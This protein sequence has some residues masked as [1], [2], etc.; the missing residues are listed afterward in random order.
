MEGSAKASRRGSVNKIMIVDDDKEIAQLVSLYLQNEGF[1]TI[2]RHHGQDALDTLEQ[3]NVSLIVL[4]VMM[5]HID[6]LEVCRNG[7]IKRR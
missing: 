3:E 2:V 5:P 4:D 6:G 7:E 1:Q